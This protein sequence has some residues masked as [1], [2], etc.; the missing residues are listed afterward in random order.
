VC[1]FNSAPVHWIVDVGGYFTDAP[2]L[3]VF[4]PDGTDVS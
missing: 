4:F 3:F 1:I 2:L